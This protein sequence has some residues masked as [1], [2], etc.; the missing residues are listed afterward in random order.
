MPPIAELSNPTH[1]PPLL[2]ML[3]SI[4]DDPNA[5]GESDSTPYSIPRSLRILIVED[6]ILIA[7]DMRDLL[8]ES[9]HLVVGMA[10]SVDHAIAMALRERP[11]LVLMDIVLA[12]PRDGIDAALELRERLDVPTLFITAHPDPLMRERAKA[13]KPLGFLVKPLDEGMLRRVLARL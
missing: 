10:G 9:G 11:D 4:P 5:P 1:E 8:K 2:W 7:L 3:A 6:E 13:S 12:G